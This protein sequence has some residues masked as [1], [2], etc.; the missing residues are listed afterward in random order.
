M[1]PVRVSG[2]KWF[3][4]V[5]GAESFLRSK[6]QE[7][8]GWLDTTQLL[9][10]YHLGQKKENP[11]CHFVI[12][13][14]STLQKQSFDIRIKNLFEVV[15]GT[16]Y[17]TKLWDGN[18]GEGA[19]SYL[20]HETDAPI[21]SC[22]GYTEIHINGFKSANE[23]VQKMILI[24]KEKANTKL[25]DKALDEFTPLEYH[26]TT[27]FEIYLYMLNCIRKSENYHPGDHNLKRYVLE[28]DLKLQ[29][30]DRFR[31]YAQS[32]YDNLFR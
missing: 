8:A 21:L 5:D 31:D 4:R 30:E 29:P 17:S 24:N 10:V 3:V 12:E 1:P 26:S 6:C 14:S 9:A 16:S 25:L 20:F 22:K 15:K 27:K 7:V 13:M 11:H 23:S 19:A 28:V 2:D 32:S 18:Y